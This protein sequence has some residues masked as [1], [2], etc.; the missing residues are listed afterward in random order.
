MLSISNTGLP[1][2]KDPWLMFDRIKKSNTNS[3]S[4]GIGLSIVQKIANLYHMP[5]SYTY[6]SEVLTLTIAFVKP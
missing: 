4:L 1:L 5:I 6:K 3:D 2:E